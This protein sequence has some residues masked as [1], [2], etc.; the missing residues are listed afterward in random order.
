MQVPVPPSPNLEPQAQAAEVRWADE[1]AA[2]W[3]RHPDQARVLHIEHEGIDIAVDL[4]D[5]TYEAFEARE[6]ARRQAEDSYAQAKRE[7]ELREQEA[8]TEAQRRQSRNRR[9]RG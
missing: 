1:T 6:R 9:T 3:L 7:A 5:G 8:K 2:D 4:R